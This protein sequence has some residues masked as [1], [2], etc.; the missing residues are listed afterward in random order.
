MYPVSDPLGLQGGEQTYRYVPNPLGY[1]DP[2]GLAKNFCS[3]R[4]K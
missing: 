1:I 3:R 4:K 2:L